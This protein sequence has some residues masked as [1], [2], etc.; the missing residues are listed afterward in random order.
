MAK[1]LKAMSLAEAENC[2]LQSNDSDLDSSVG[3]LSCDEEEKVDNLL[4][5][6]YSTDS[7]RLVLIII[8][9]IFTVLPLLW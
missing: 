8:F 2:C 3:G 4:L 7:N 6:N 5:E 1:R 9:K